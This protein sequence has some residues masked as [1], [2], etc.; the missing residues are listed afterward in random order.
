ML[1]IGTQ[2]DCKRLSHLPLQIQVE[3]E[4]IITRLNFHYGEHR[5]IEDDKGGYVLI[6]ENTSDYEMVKG[7]FGKP[8]YELIP[9]RVKKIV[10]KERSYTSSLIRFNSNCSITLISTIFL[11]PLSFLDYMENDD[12][13]K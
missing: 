8:I 7:I 9:E 12:N 5:N 4:G 11:T 13:G 1:K 10:T 2:E 6:I 3:V